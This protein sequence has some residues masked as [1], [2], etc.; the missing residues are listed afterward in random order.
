MLTDNLVQEE[1][2]DEVHD[3]L[4]FQVDQIK[5]ACRQLPSGYRI[6]LSLYLFEGY[7]TE[8]IGTILNI[9]PG[10]VRTQYLRGKRKLLTL[11]A[12]K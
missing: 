7:D 12:E 5:A 4:A 9:Q 11:L 2:D 1:S 3:Q 6:I 10:T 8:E